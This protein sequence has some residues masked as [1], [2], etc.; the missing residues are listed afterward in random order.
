MRIDDAHP[1]RATTTRIAVIT[2]GVAMAVAACGTTTS[3]GQVSVTP[4]SA[5]AAT[6]PQPA[7]A[8]SQASDAPAA[9]PD[10]SS[11]GV[12]AFGQRYTFDSGLAVDVP[13]PVPYKPSSSAAGNDT[14]EV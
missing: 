5:P 2:I 8:A 1:R 12:A 9:R 4:L 10:D 6:S 11:S 3:G 14:G 7:S 13:Q